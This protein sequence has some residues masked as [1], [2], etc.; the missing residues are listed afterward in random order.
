LRGYAFAAVKL[1][2]RLYH[3]V[4]SKYPRRQIV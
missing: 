1:A 2:H 3:Y 4:I